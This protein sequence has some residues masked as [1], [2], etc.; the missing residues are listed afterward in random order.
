MKGGLAAITLAGVGST[1][2]FLLNKKGFV[3][4][5]YAG[6]FLTPLPIP[7]LLENLDKTGLTAQFKMAA[8]LGQRTFFP[9][10]VTETAGYNGNFLGPTIRVRNGQRFN[11]RVDNNLP[12]VTT[13]ALAWSAS[14]G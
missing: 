7:P 1:G 13:S 14:S 8:Q 9:G 3:S 12:E 6:D 11:L 4:T 5:A 2:L 10:K